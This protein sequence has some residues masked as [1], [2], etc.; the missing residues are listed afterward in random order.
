M[1]PWLVVLGILFLTLGLGTAAAL[2]FSGQDNPIPS[3]TVTPPLNYSLAP[4][5]TDVAFLAGSNG[6][7]EV[8]H[9]SWHSSA[10][11][12][13]LLQEQV[14]CHAPCA[15]RQLLV[16]W[17]INRSGSWEG[18]GPFLYPLIC[19]LTNDHGTPVN[20]TLSSRA[21]STMPSHVSLLF[22]LILG[23]G[24][25]ALLIVGGVAVFLG[26]FLRDDPYGPDP[27]LVSRSADDVE[28]LAAD[29]PSDH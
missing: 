15:D 9:L 3:S 10:P 8:F 11:V 19:V 27:T 29:P 4:N 12:D 20:V 13:V 22:A 28:E 18:F 23:G 1:R 14:P 17:S 7:S 5:Q 21:D 24:A 16:N 2:Y 26:V 25:A 6:S